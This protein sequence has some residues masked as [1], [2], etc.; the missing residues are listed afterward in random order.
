MFTVAG[1]YQS[2]DAVN[3]YVGILKGDLQFEMSY[4]ITV[5]KQKTAAINPQHFEFSLLLRQ[6][7]GEGDFVLSVEVEYTWWLLAFES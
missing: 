4:D 7:G 2:G 1:W 6:P 3:P 5:S